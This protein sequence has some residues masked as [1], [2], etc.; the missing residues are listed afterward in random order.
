MRA[1]QVPV[2]PT[3]LYSLPRME[4]LEHPD[5]APGRSISDRWFTTPLVRHRGIIALYPTI[6]PILRLRHTCDRGVVTHR[7]Q[8]YPAIEYWKSFFLQDA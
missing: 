4:C 8:G 2:F 3:A 1:S 5:Y 6:R 7:R